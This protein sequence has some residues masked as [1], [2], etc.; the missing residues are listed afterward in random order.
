MDMRG[1]V[2]S[3]TPEHHKLSHKDK[4]RTIFLRTSA[5]ELLRP[6]VADTDAFY[7]GY[8]FSPIRV[9]DIRLGRKPGTYQPK[10]NS[11]KPR[12]HYYDTSNYDRKLKS[13]CVAAGVSVFSS[14]QLRHSYLTEVS[15]LFGIEAAAAV[16]G[17]SKVETTAVY[18]DRN[19]KK[20]YEVANTPTKTFELS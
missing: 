8:F 12:K 18:I 4:K 13:A 10:P 5:V 9:E 7:G 16:G 11:K 1:D 6:L 20:A 2:W 15:E 17:H 14:N 19:D 3:F